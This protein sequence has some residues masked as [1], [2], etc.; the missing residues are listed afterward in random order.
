MGY[1]C[2]SIK[3]IAPSDLLKPIKVTFQNNQQTKTVDFT[4]YNYIKRALMLDNSNANNV[5]LKKTVTALV[6]YAKKAEAYFNE[7]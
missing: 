6:D 3:E 7:P 5:Q 4:V 1:L 2:Y